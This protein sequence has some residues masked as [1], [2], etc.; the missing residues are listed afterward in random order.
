EF[1]DEPERV[2]ARRGQ[3]ASRVVRRDRIEVLET[4]EQEESDAR[5]GQRG[6]HAPGPAASQDT[7]ESDGYD[8]RRR[9]RAAQQHG[10]RP[11]KRAPLPPAEVPGHVGGKE[12]DQGL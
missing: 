8:V 2:I 4:E 1:L 10:N 9:W 5:G 6:T 12:H 3:E 11:G 7:A